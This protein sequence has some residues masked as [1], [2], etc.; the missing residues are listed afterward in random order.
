MCTLLST[1]RKEGERVPKCNL[2]GCTDFES[3][4]IDAA[5]HAGPNL[6]I[7]SVQADVCTKCGNSV[8]TSTDEEKLESAREAVERGDTAGMQVVGTIYRLE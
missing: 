2:C 1:T 5:V 4:I 7:V 8:I 6:V 3:Q